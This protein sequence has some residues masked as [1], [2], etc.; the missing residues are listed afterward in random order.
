MSI[1]PVYSLEE[2]LES[3]FLDTNQ[4][5][6]NVPHPARPDLRVLANPIRINGQ[7]LSQKV[8]SAPGADNNEI[9]GARWDAAD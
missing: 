4:M 2:A 5:V 8:C 3:P 9:L 6:A 1:A 7:R